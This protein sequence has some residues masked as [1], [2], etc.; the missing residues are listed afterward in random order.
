MSKSKRHSSIQTQHANLSKQGQQWLDEV[1]WDLLEQ[2]DLEEEGQV[3]PM[4][5]HTRASDLQSRQFSDELMQDEMPGATS[6]KISQIKD[7]FVDPPAA[8]ADIVHRYH[9]LKATELDELKAISDERNSN[10]GSKINKK[11]N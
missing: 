8:V 2:L 9:D 3:L 7:L 6:P 4:R 5:D 11:G 10:L 1:D